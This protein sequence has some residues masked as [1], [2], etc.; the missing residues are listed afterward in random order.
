MSIAD[1]W[2]LPDGVKEILPPEARQIES[3]RRSLLDLFD[4]WGYDLVMPPMVEYLESL[5]TGTG[6]DL[7]LSTFKVTDQ[8]TGRM[9]GLRAD[10]TPQVARIDA[11]SL[12]HRS[13][14][15][16]CYANSVLHTVP[17]TL[18]A[19]RSPLQI[20]A[21][22]YGHA[23]VES[24]LEV[25]GLMLAAL[26]AGGVER[27]TLDLGHV[28]IYRALVA[29]AQLSGDDEAELFRLLQGK[30]MT[31]LAE[32]LARLPVT[33]QQRA[34]LQ[35]L[36]TLSGDRSVLARA[37]TLLAGDPAIDSALAALERVADEVAVLFPAVT[38][39]FDLAELR[40]YNY[41]TGL[42]FAAYV[43]GYGQAVAK[44]GRYD[45]IGRV[46]GRARPATGFSADLKV[47]VELSSAAVD[48]VG[49]ILAPAEGSVALGAA[50]GELRAAGE[51]VVCALPGA[52]AD[53]A[54]MGCNRKLVQVDGK[55]RV[56]TV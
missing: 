42:V 20:G 4:S 40:G 13:P 24:D 38:L 37:R 56:A 47:I 1:R 5:L 48:P 7:G 10:T 28:G 36:S 27:V 54:D 6:N 26:V 39:Y 52:E 55:W 49:G 15:R 32:L 2:L 46:F 41:H 43:A 17:A 33:E 50:I 45:E 21:E 19:G 14:T 9:M 18:Q 12:N 35:V 29:Q 11:H 3:L 30:A 44:G 16:L 25:V 31:E 8:L 23:G 22:L 34:R 51:R 53:A